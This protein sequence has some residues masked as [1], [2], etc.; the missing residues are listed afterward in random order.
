MCAVQRDNWDKAVELY[1]KAR[2]ESSRIISGNE[3]SL[4]LIF[5]R[6]VSK[7]ELSSKEVAEFAPINNK[8][9]LSSFND[10]EVYLEWFEI[11]CRIDVAK[12]RFVLYEYI[13]D[14]TPEMYEVF[15]VLNDNWKNGLE[16][17]INRLSK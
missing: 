6:L 13:T 8:H 7:K 10:K 2:L 14:E 15:L 16:D 12:D 9:Y 1:K 4:Y 5:D 17:F 3:E 11:I